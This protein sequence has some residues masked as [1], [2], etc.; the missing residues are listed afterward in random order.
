MQWAQCQLTGLQQEQ[1]V[2]TNDHQ[3]MH[4]RCFPNHGNAARTGADMQ[5]LALHQTS[6]KQIRLSGGMADPQDVVEPPHAPPA[7]SC[8]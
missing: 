6:T 8:V 3:S 7:S 5:L 1:R 4:T 2:Y